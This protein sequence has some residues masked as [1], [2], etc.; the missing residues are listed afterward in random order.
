VK[1]TNHR[2]AARGS[3][4]L[5]W[6][7]LDGMATMRIPWSDILPDGRLD[8]ELVNRLRA[9][10]RQVAELRQGDD[11]PPLPTANAKIHRIDNSVFER[12]LTVRLESYRNSLRFQ[13]VENG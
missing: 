13:E 6:S 5:C 11:W 7:L 2:R 3:S 9:F 4:Y 8:A 10:E 12:D 1:V